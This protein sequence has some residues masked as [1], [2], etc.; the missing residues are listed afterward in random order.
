MN[1]IPLQAIE[2]AKKRLTSIIYHNPLS[3][4]PKLSQLSKAQVFLKKENLQLTGS[5]KIRG[6][7]NK[8]SALHEEGKL[9]HGVIAAS[10]GNHAQGVAYS[11]SHFKVKSVVVMPEATPLL[12]VESTRNL[13]AEVLLKGTNYDEAYAYALKMAKEKNYTFIH[14]FADSEVAAGQGTIALEMLDEQD[15]DIVL[16][17]VGGGGLISGVASAY[18][19]INPNVKVI[20]VSAKGARAMF[21]SFHAK[22]IIKTDSVKTIADGIAV[23][24]VNEGIFE[25]IKQG[26]DDMVEVDDEEIASAI[27][28]LIES[29]KLVVEGAG[30]VGIAALLHNKLDLHPHQKVGVILS[31]GNIDVTMLNLIIEKG[32]I[33]TNRKTKF[34]ITL[35][36]KPGSL[37]KLTD[38]LTKMDANIVHVSYDRISTKLEYGDAYISITLETKGLEHKEKIRNIMLENGYKFSE[39]V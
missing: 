3:Y 38:L 28:Y 1:L 24:D 29:Q 13:G 12:K 9:T 2:L 30:A 4:A 8:L 35:I 33:K 5:F 6:A 11:A 39:I 36:D 37:M 21:E 18:R 27:L 23:R 31:G 32:L 7:F 34:R 22:R 19:L 26:V 17:P 16:V 25:C 14:P 15:L 10:A 20:G